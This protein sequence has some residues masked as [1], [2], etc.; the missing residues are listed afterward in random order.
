MSS[1]SNQPRDS[2]RHLSN[3]TLEEQN[4]DIDLRTLGHLNERH[5]WKPPEQRSHQ[6]WDT[7]KPRGQ[8]PARLVPL[9]PSPLLSHE[10]SF[11]I[12][13]TDRR[14]L[15]RDADFK[16]NLITLDENQVLKS[17]TMGLLKQHQT[18]TADPEA[19][20]LPVIESARQYSTDKM[21]EKYGMSDKELAMKVLA[22]PFFGLTKQDKFKNMAKFNREVLGKDDLLISNVLHSNESANYLEQKLLHVSETNP[23][24]PALNLCLKR[25][26]YIIMHSFLRRGDYSNCRSTISMLSK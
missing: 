16:T 25:F 7:S 5:L 8:T 11:V 19:F 3:Y 18:S 14:F 1:Q 15:A 9:L 13:T 2:L 23:F 20:T 26:Y 10:P 4:I 12:N 24:F 6:P 17:S 22:S 21:D